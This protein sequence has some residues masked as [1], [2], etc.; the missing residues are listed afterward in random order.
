MVTRRMRNP[1]G[2]E[3]YRGEILCELQ[4]LGR[5]YPWWWRQMAMQIGEPGADAA[6]PPSNAFRWLVSPGLAPAEAEHEAFPVKRG[7]L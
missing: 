5:K 7:G 2:L 1:E 4:G 3:C 6:V